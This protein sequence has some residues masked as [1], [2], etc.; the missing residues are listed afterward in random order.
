MSLDPHD[1]LR[2]LSALD[3]IRNIV[4]QMDGRKACT[5]CTHLKQGICEKWDAK[6]P[7]EYLKVGC[8]E[9]VFD[10]SSPPF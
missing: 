10:I 3:E 5:T 2:L 4:E 8:R 6:P 1:R 7:L 9:W